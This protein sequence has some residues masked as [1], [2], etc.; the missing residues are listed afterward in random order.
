MEVL[1]VFVSNSTGIKLKE[2]KEK[3]D[4]WVLDSRRW[5]AL[6]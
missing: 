2:V 5:R 1:A 4:S 6:V 3:I